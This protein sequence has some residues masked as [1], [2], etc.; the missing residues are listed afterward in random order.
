MWEAVGAEI[1]GGRAGM[2]GGIP[3]RRGE[4]SL[5]IY[6]GEKKGTHTRTPLEAVRVKGRGEWPLV[7]DE[8]RRR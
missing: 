6:S 4:E 3:K 1:V 7:D 8:I 2:V 5:I